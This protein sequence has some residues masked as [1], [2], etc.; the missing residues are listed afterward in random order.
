[1]NR[2]DRCRRAVVIAWVSAC[3]IL[4]PAMAV[5]RFSVAQP[6]TP[7]LNVSAAT[8][9]APTGVVGTYLCNPVGGAMQ[10]SV[11]NFTD[12]GPGSSG[13][14]YTL[15]SEYGGS[16]SATSTARSQTLV[17][18]NSGGNGTTSWTLLITTR[19]SSWTSPTYTTQV[20]CKGNKTEPGTL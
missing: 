18:L 3:L 20:V 6:P 17:V 2:F 15:T 9:V 16:A 10:V 8:M 12:A 5:A 13:Y 4:V 11:A 19:L 7:R 14:T 1:M